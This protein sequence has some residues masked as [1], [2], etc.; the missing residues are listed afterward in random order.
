M[1]TTLPFGD[2]HVAVPGF[3][4]MGLNSGMGKDLDFEQAEPVLLKAV[5]LG[6]TFWDTAV[7]NIFNFNDGFRF[8][9]ASGLQVVY[10]N[11]ENEKLLGN[12]I[13]KHTVRDKL[14][15]EHNISLSLSFHHCDVSYPIAI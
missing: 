2:L 9:I 5:E 13:K 7:N 12:F 4:A 14:F 8:L 11:G 15:G 10:K 6:C 1:V 3:G